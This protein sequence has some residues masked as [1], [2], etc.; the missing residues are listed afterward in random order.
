MAAVILDTDQ[1]GCI[2]SLEDRQQQQP[3]HYWVVRLATR[4]A[5]NTVRRVA[6]FRAAQCSKTAACYS[7]DSPVA[8]G[9]LTAASNVFLHLADNSASKQLGPTDRLRI[10]RV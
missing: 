6:Q 2:S 3:S 8:S 1:W 10:R 4:K 9:C 7:E 5:A